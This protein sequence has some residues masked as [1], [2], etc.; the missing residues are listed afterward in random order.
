MK[1]I[2]EINRTN[3]EVIDILK[4]DPIHDLFDGL[5]PR[6]L[7]VSPEEFKVYP[8]SAKGSSPQDD[9]QHYNEWILDN[10]P[11][12]YDLLIKRSQNL[13]EKTLIQ[14]NDE[15]EYKNTNKN[16]DIKN[17]NNVKSADKFIKGNFADTAETPI[18][19]WQIG[20]LEIDANSVE[21]G[22]N[23]EYTPNSMELGNYSD[24]PIIPENSPT[25]WDHKVWFQQHWSGIR[26]FLK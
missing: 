22:V 24:L 17:I 7:E 16:K 11:K 13:V 23:V 15:S 3:P 21:D 18:L 20:E 19:Y 14:I 2:E 8:G 6:D 5:D 1:E 10:L 12:A 9:P 26:D 4:S 25:A